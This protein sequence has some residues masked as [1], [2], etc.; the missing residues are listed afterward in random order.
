MMG[1]ALEVLTVYSE[2]LLYKA[3]MKKVCKKTN[4]DDEDAL[5][6]SFAQMSKKEMMKRGLCFKCGKKS[7]QANECPKDEEEEEGA[8]RYPTAG[9]HTEYTWII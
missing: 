4:H 5:E 7:H 9:Q 6:L 1:E 3:I 2:Q 8:E